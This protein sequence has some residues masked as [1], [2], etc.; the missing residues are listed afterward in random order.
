LNLIILILTSILF[1]F[2]FVQWQLS[3]AEEF[4]SL[5]KNNQYPSTLNFK[6]PDSLIKSDVDS[7]SNISI[8]QSSGSDGFFSATYETQVNWL[9]GYKGPLSIIKASLSGPLKLYP[10]H[11]NA[12]HPTGTWKVDCD[13]NY[14]TSWGSSSGEDHF[15]GNA[16][17]VYPPEPTGLHNNWIGVNRDVDLSIRGTFGIT[18]VATCSVSSAFLG[19]NGYFPGSFQPNG[20]IVSSGSVDL[21]SVPYPGQIMVK[22][23]FSWDI[24]L[25]PPH[26][27]PPIPIIDVFPPNNID[28]GTTVILDGSRSYDPD[29]GDN[30]TS[31]MWQS[32]NPSVHLNSTSGPIVQFIAPEV[33]IPTNIL[34]TLTVKDSFSAEGSAVIPIRVSPCSPD[35][36]PVEPASTERLTATQMSC[37]DNDNKPVLDVEVNP[38]EINPYP[39]APFLILSGITITAKNAD[40]TPLSGVGVKVESCTKI[41]RHDTDGHPH[42]FRIFPCIKGDRPHASL[43]WD[44]HRGNPITVT[45]D[46]NGI[47][48]IMYFPPKTTIGSKTYYTSGV[49]QILA[50]L[51]TDPSIKDD[52]KTITT[53]VPDL[54]PLIGSGGC[55]GGG[56]FFFDPQDN[57]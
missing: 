51:V 42:D 49:D 32:L 56:T 20:D 33:Q 41:G 24:V 47:A 44:I 31:Y 17:L 27:N 21:P 48:K 13:E 55:I 4:S 2:Y 52:S 54:Q 30:I 40:G 36:G 28:S 53:K 18:D 22:N 3:D 29:P 26:N 46:S 37:D 15:H 57:H 34:I 19:F 35:G 1:T 12:Y 45:T 16:V 43:V 23:H 8:S 5:I 25:G 10:N 39:S 9:G 38:P 6:T 7:S 50:T 11:N 14:Y